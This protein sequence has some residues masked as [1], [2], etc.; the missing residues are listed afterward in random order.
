MSRPDGYGFATM[1]DHVGHDFGVSQ[2]VV[3]DQ[4]RIDQF[5]DATL[6][7]QWVHV[8]VERARRESPFGGPIAHGFL[9]LSLIAGMIGSCGVL[10]E[11]A[12]A[13]F[14]YGVENVRF[15]SPV[16]AGAT[17]RARFVLKGVELKAEG[18]KLVRVVGTVEIDG[19]PKPALVG[20]FL[21]L[22]AA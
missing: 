14:N 3:V 21:A 15:L 18:R 1:Q 19:A 4:A 17:I 12:G 20:E 6:D 13:F 10:P 5:A 8:D 9:T 16:P 2:P 7:H 11:D 22:V